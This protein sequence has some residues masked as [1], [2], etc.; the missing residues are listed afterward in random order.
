MLYS[1]VSSI[2]DWNLDNRLLDKINRIY[3]VT[4]YPGNIGMTPEGRMPTMEEALSYLEFAKKV[5]AVFTELV[6]K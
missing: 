4:R 1:E 3:T 5:E 2:H 6:G